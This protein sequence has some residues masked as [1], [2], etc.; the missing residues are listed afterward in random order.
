MGEWRQRPL[1]DLVSLQRG[2][3][4]PAETRI[5][6][7][8][9]VVGSGGISGWHNEARE[10]GPGVVVGRAGASIGKPTLVKGAYWPLNTTLFVKDFKG[11]DPRWVYYLFEITDFAGYNSGGAQPMLN[12]NYI[13]DLQ[14]R[15]PG[16]SEQRAIADLLGALDDKISANDR[17]IANAESLMIVQAGNASSRTSVADLAEQ[18]K[19]TLSPGYFDAKVAH[20]SLP[21]FDE[22][23]MPE[24]AS[25]G[26]IKSN[27]ILI[28]EPCVLMSKLNPRIPRIW[29]L[30][31]LPGRMSLAST[32]FVALVPGR[33]S[34]SLLWATLSE[35]SVSVDL[36]ANVAGTSGSHQRVKP[37]ELLALR[38]KDPRALAREVQ[39]SIADLGVLCHLRRM[40]SARLRV[41]RSQLLPLLMSGKVWVREAEK[42]VEGV[43]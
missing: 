1:R 29:D 26:S 2:Y 11:N 17:V 32:E 27:K 10:E 13:A 43:V 37:A 15:T 8:V 20:F 12:R 21:S 33:I 38:V 4:L 16:I 35:P 9:P 28:S 34:S 19:A 24:I 41:T 7:T 5:T 25:G 23:K 14:V 6:G 18:H 22:G 3:D 39:Q 31:A 42:V 40:E 30:A 36:A